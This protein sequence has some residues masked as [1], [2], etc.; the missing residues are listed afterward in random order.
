VGIDREPLRLMTEIEQELRRQGQW[1]GR[2]PSPRALASPLPFCCDTL[3]FTQ[4]LQWVF[5]PHTRA[6]AES[7]RPLPS[8][9]GVRPMAEEALRG[10]TWD[11]GALLQLL[12]RFDGM[13]QIRKEMVRR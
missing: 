13:I 2:A 8:A 3:R 1:E 5:V 10:C 12:G 6:L 11:T 4:W 7:G 9:S